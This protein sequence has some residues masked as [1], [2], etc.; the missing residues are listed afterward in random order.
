MSVPAID[1]STLPGPAQKILDPS[2]PAPLKAMAAKGLMPGLGPGA[3][4][5][6]IVA[7]SLN[8]DANADQA[9]KTL[10][11]LPPPL[12]NGAL[13]L[14]D[15]HP[16]V[17]DALGPLYAR[18]AAVSE[19]IL[20]HPQLL[21]DTV[22]GMAAVGTEGVCEL[23]A[24]NE[25]RLL[26]HPA[27]IEKLYTN[28][29]CRMST[30]D[31]LLELAVRNEIE[32]NIPAFAQAKAAIQG[33][34][35]AEPTEEAS[36]DDTQ[37]SDGMTK[38]AD[39]HLGDDEDTHRINEETGQEEVVAKA[40]PLHAIWAEL[41]PPAKI[42][43][44]TIGTMREYDENGREIGEQRF[45]AKALRMLGV[46]DANPLVAVAAMN[47]PGVSDAE[48]VRI[49]GM[50]NVA[51]DVLRDI[52]FNKDWTRHYMV[53]YNLV[54]NPRT[55]FGQ[56]SKFVLHLR[57]SDIKNLAKSKEVSGAIQAAAKQQ[58]QRKGKS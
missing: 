56:A 48:V 14:P 21:P 37:F 20:F 12:L 23:I 29:N 52:A 1:P 51:E 39:L 49:A 24:T 50:R 38:A 36:F 42:R 32:L 6:V 4:L 45:D 35:I 9:K 31:R 44:L 33:E 41:R 28:K 26:A 30:A 57:E 34:L 8:N 19:K 22:I 46:R 27:I 2:G 18:D 55:P 25:E 13:A 11:K 53:K 58:L 15:L 3:I 16:A 10:E 40:R 5:A 43:L 7:L 17:L 54:A 47:T